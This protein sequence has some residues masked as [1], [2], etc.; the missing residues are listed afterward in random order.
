LRTMAADILAE[1]GDRQNS[2][3]MWQQMY[4]QA[5]EGVLKANAR[6]RILAL[7]AEDLAEALSA[8]VIAYEGLHGAKPRT[9]DDLRVARLWSGPVVDPS[10]APFLYD[11]TDGRVSIS[12]KSRLWRPEKGQRKP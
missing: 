8:R 11:G 12:P 9:L 5:E 4:D 10:G 6:Q 3:Q 1:S 2:R 7:D